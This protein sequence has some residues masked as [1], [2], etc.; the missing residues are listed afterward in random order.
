MS[1]TNAPVTSA[2]VLFRV[3][4]AWLPF[5]VVW[6]LFILAWTGGEVGLVE[7]LESGA[8]AIGTAAILGF[9][10]WRFTGHFPWPDRIRFRFYLIHLVAGTVFATVWLVV[11]DT[12]EILSSGMDPAEFLQEVSRVVGFQ[13]LMG[14]WIYGGVAAVSYTLRI[15]ERL[16]EQ[17][18]IAASAQVLAAQA[19]LRALKAQLN[20]HFLFNALHSVSFLVQ[21]DPDEADSAIDQLGGLLRY[22]LDEGVNDEVL[23]MDE[24]AFTS[25]YLDLESIR[26]GSRLR[27]DADLDPDAMGC[28][29][30][31]F[32]LQPLVENCVQ[33]GIDP[34]PEG[35]LIQIRA[36]VDGDR[37]RITVQDDGP[38]SD[39]VR[40]VDEG[41]GLGD[42]RRRLEALYGDRATVEV[43]TGSGQGFLVTLTLPVE[44]TEEGGLVEAPATP[45]DSTP[46]PVK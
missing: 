14:L 2:P 15:R 23:L 27:V 9:F 7:A 3:A 33:H 25:A 5:F 39:A 43:S 44:E 31:P 13:L 8:L 19:Q 36:A 10:V 17:E 37:L 40:V 16:R 34:R 29:V 20:P 46:E 12:I 42:L 22:A 24:W 35:G 28:A 38:G 1:E 21:E 32:S 11:I 4:L 41:H 6:V 30:P 45:G 26:F 18:R